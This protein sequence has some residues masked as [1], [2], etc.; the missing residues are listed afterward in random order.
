M[1]NTPICVPFASAAQYREYVDHP[2]PY[3]QYLSEML[4]Q[5]PELFPQDMDQGFPFHDAYASV[6]QDVIVRR[7]TL[8]TTGAVFSLRPSFVMPSM[9]GRT[10]AVEKARSR[11]QWGGPFA[12]LAYVFGRDAMCW[13]RAWLA[14]GRP[15]LV[16]TTIKEPQTL[17]R[18]LVADE[19]LT[20][21]AKHQV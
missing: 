2:A 10:E 11:R 7:I 20:R 16:G 9:I 19:Q 15:S 1:G 17:P 4:H 21:V 14:C 18:D 3:R 12:A 13:Y 8:H 6:K 5:Y